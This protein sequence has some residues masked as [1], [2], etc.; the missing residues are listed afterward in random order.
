[1]SGVGAIGQALFNP[2]GADKLFAQLR[3]TA[4]SRLGA[5]IDARASELGDINKYPDLSRLAAAETVA[6]ANDTV[7]FFVALGELIERARR[8]G[9]QVTYD[10]VF[11]AGASVSLTKLFSAAIS[12]EVGQ[13]GAGV[14]VSGALLG[15]EL[16]LGAGTSGVSY[17]PGNLGGA[18]YDPP[19][20]ITS[21]RKSGVSNPSGGNYEDSYELTIEGGAVAGTGALGGG[22]TGGL[23]AK[24][25]IQ[26]RD[27]FIDSTIKDALFATGGYFSD[28]TVKQRFIDAGLNP[29]DLA[30]QR[31]ILDEIKNVS[32]DRNDASEYVSIGVALYR[33]TNGEVQDFSGLPGQDGIRS[34]SGQANGLAGGLI[35]TDVQDDNLRPIFIITDGGNGRLDIDLRYTQRHLGTDGSGSAEY[36]RTES[37]FLLEED[38]SAY[39]GSHGMAIDST[40]GYFFVPQSGHLEKPGDFGLMA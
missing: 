38:G 26:S 17:E 16:A 39:R 27:Q 19:F 34:T 18:I 40:F 33:L 7:S 2:I 15:A 20:L 25:T 37:R 14:S 13:N 1:M 8:S 29:D 24:I 11:G 4:R 12:F 32:I 35:E 31:H 30:T 28:A 9:Y 5:K 36:F 10:L 21:K 22:A 3:H 23:K 6:E